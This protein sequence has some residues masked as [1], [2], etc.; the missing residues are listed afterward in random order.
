MRT[1][2]RGHVYATKARAATSTGCAGAA[3]GTLPQGPLGEKPRQKRQAALRNRL[4]GQHR[5]LGV[6]AGRGRP[7]GFSSGPLEPS[8]RGANI[9][10]VGG[11]G[12]REPG[13]GRRRGGRQPAV[14]GERAQR[15]QARGAG[16]PGGGHRS[17][18]PS[19]RGCGKDA[20][21]AYE[22]K[23]HALGAIRGLP[24]QPARERGISR[25]RRR[26]VPAR[27][28]RGARAHPVWG[29]LLG[30]RSGRRARPHLRRP[31]PGRRRLRRR[32]RR[33]V[34]AAPLGQRRGTGAVLRV[35]GVRGRGASDLD[36]LARLLCD[37]RLGHDAA[38]APH[39]APRSPAQAALVPTVFV[40]ALHSR[41][42]HLAS[43]L[44]LGLHRS[45]AGDA[46]HA[47]VL[48]L[49]RRPHAPPGR[50]GLVPLS[51]AGRRRA[52]RAKTAGGRPGGGRQGTRG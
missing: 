8:H 27:P 38:G 14:R 10:A 47:S 43:V 3:E 35:R 20:A 1:D 19:Q 44:G 11:G 15:G 30:R 5:W 45:A 51:A 39:A 42:A 21:G 25:A 12:P 4:P 23:R 49:L 29:R 32:R 40:E 26:D 18:Q 50:V 41:A 46:D 17:G 37:L 48:L 6:F 2:R 34:A 36:A 22:G 24:P 16:A 31:R 13:G 9:G 52:P 33:G 28:C 7:Q